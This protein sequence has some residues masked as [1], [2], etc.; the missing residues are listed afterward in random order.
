MD[1]ENAGY[2]KDGLLLGEGIRYVRLFCLS[3][4]SY[5]SYCAT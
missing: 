3:R 2:L 5:V 4:H 1:H